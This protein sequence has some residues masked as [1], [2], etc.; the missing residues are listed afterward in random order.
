M[1]LIPFNRG[2]GLEMSK[3]L[4]ESG[5]DVAMMYVSND[6]AKD[7]AAEIGKQYNVFC[8]AYKAEITNAEEVTKVIDQIVKEMGGVDIFVANAGVNIGGEAVVSLTKKGKLRT[9]LIIVYTSLTTWKAGVRCLTL[10]STVYSMVSKPPPN[11]CSSKVRVMSSLPL[12]SLL[13]SSTVL[14]SNA[15]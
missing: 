9:R 13:L 2:I 4:A 8:Q 12:L 6:K 5:A 3:A 10:T 7:L 14:K 1:T 11:T 15:L